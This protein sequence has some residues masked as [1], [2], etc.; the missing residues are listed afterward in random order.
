MPATGGDAAAATA[1][2]GADDRDAEEES[3]EA[4]A[5]ATDGGDVPQPNAD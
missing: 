3:L 4:G 2:T 1:L 5:P